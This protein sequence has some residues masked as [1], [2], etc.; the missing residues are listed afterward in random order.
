MKLPCAIL[1]FPTGIDAR[2]A[3]YLIRRLPEYVHA[4]T[5]NDSRAV[6]IAPEQGPRKY[7][8]TQTIVRFRPRWEPRNGWFPQKP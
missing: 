6:F 1:H 8:L 2:Q 4:V 5:A 3:R 7:A